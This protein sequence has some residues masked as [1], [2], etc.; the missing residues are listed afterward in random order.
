MKIYTFVKETGKHVTQFD[1]DFVMSRIVV[2]DSETRIGCMHLGTAG[3][4]GG[5]VAAADQ[6]LLIVSGKGKVSGQENEWVDVH[7]GDAVYWQVSEW[8]ETRSETGM[9]AIVVE[10]EEL[11]PGRFMNVK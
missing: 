7:S 2:T 11:Y 1:S 5:H 3:V 8:H 10:A 9:T 6:L 4:I